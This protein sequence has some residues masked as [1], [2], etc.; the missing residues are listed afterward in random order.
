MHKSNF[1]FNIIL[2]IIILTIIG[3]N[4][5]NLNKLT[6]PIIIDD[7]QPSYQTINSI[8]HIYDPLGKLVYKLITNQAYYFSHQKKS[9]FIKPVLTIYNTKS[10]PIWKITADQAKL[11]DD[12]ILYLHGNV[13]INNLNKNLNLKHIL[14]KNSIINLITQDVISDDRVIIIGNGFKTISM[15]IHGNIKKHIAELDENVKTYY[16]QLN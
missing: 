2:I 16:E 13:Q 5:T 14:M 12:N 6:E 3:W 7:Y 9:C 8:T 4:F 11:T 10:I 1:F 15:K